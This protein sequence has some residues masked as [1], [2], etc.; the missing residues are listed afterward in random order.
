MDNPIKENVSV[1]KI[2]GFIVLSMVVFALADA[3]GL[4]NW[5]L[6]PYSTIKGK[7]FAPKA[8]STN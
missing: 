3:T 6:Y 2:V 4:T 5:I 1:G 8:A 7:F